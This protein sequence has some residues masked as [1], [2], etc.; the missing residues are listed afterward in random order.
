MDDKIKDILESDYKF[1]LISGDYF[2]CP[3]CNPGAS[4][5]ANTFWDE[6][7]L[8]EYICAN[9]NKKRMEAIWLIDSYGNGDMVKYCDIYTKTGFH[10]V[11]NLEF[12]LPQTGTVIIH[13]GDNG[14][15]V[16]DEAYRTLYANNYPRT[17][18]ED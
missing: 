10:N 5:G 12:Q 6:K 4:L 18:Q 1:V 11:V 2:D 14:W 16:A 3:S 9:T 17:T 7:Q 13:Q 15:Q 8:L